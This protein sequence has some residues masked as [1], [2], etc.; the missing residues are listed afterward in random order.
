MFRQ[1]PASLRRPD[2]PGARRRR[3]RAGLVAA[4]GGAAAMA[5]LPDRLRLD[6]R[7]PF[8]DVAAWRPHAAVTAAAGA[9]VLATGKGS[10]PAAAVVGTVALAGIS[11][12]ARR[13]IAAPAPAPG[14]GDLTIL[15]ANVLKGRADTGELARLIERE[16][17]DVVVLPEAGPDFRDKL[18]PLVADLGYR[19]WVSAEPGTADLWGV[20][21]LASARAGDLR[22]RTG[23]EMRCH[24]LQATGGILG[25]RDLFAVH[26][27][28]PLKP[29]W[30]PV[31][32]SDLELVAGWCGAP[33][34]P[35]VAGDFNATLD[36]S[37]LR[38]GLGGC[39]SAATGTGRALAGTYPSS[40]PRWLGI[41]I[42]HVLV[43][44]D[45]V[46]TRFEIVDVAGSD[47]RA[48]LARVRLAPA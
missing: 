16:T 19:S 15:S 26:A 27:A 33:V 23:Y 43:P 38:A 14:P 21:L 36:H 40:L 5:V 7:F 45:A 46:T 48:V 24:Y 35:I 9:A 32:R 34:P 29:R 25:R 11:A 22:V 12:V 10:R 39:R 1:R 3:L 47:H 4:A 20:T 2:P 28:S 41:Q 8:V 42:D 30:T 18:M 17:P 31:W 6:R 44:A 13:A 37:L